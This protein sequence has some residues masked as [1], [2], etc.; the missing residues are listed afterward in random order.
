MI[1]LLLV[2]YLTKGIT[3]NIEHF[4]QLYTQKMKE[5]NSTKRLNAIDEY[6]TTQQDLDINENLTPQ[7]YLLQIIQLIND[8]PN[9]SDD[10]ISDLV[11]ILNDRYSLGEPYLFSQIETNIAAEELKE[12]FEQIFIGIQSYESFDFELVDPPTFDRVNNQVELKIRYTDYFINNFNQERDR[13]LSSGTIQLNFLLNEN[14]CI[15]SKSGFNKLFSKLLEFIGENIDEFHFKHVYVQNKAKSLRNSNFAPLTLLAIHLIY[16]KLQD[17]GFKV[18][19][20]SSITFNNEK[21]PFVKN[22]KLGGSNLFKDGDV[23]ERIYRGDK[24]TKFSVSLFRHNQTQNNA[25]IVNLTIDFKSILK[26]TFDDNEFSE[27]RIQSIAIDLYNGINTLLQSTDTIAEA[28]DLLKENLKNVT[29]SGQLLTR[30]LE[31]VKDDLNDILFNSDPDIITD[32][33]KYF[34][35]KYDI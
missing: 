16:K 15:S 9:E 20:V 11:M 32:I 18:Q 22:A 30:F 3:M 10:I 5:R 6:L 4:Q 26:I 35:E 23:I 29:T 33:N 17:L 13:E 24:I 28:E 1:S 31:T 12:T 25:V 19:S 2:H 14:I 8:N 34:E 21:A 7:Q 27:R